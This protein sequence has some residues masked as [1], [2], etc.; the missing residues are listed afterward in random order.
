MPYAFRT[1]FLILSTNQSDY[2]SVRKKGNLTNVSVNIC[3]FHKNL[4]SLI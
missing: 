1:G 4:D 3:P 2:C